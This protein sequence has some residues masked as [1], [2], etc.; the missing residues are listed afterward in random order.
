M[1]KNKN[2]IL[3][4][5]FDQKYILIILLI[6]SL[7]F[8]YFIQKNI[9]KIDK[10][11]QQ[12]NNTKVIF[13][14]YLYQVWYEKSYSSQ[15][16]IILGAVFDKIGVEAFLKPKN[17][18]V[19]NPKQTNKYIYFNVRTLNPIIVEDFIDKFEIEKKNFIEKEIEMIEN[20]R[21][22]KKDNNI[23][24]DREF[25]IF[26]IKNVKI[27][28]KGNKRVRE[29]SRDYAEKIISEHNGNDKNRSE[30][31]QSIKNEAIE[32]KKTFYYPEII[33]LLIYIGYFSLFFFVKLIRDNN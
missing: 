5:I 3:K 31:I 29:A 33:I 30:N 4:F 8:S 26:K 6:V 16:N 20:F 27:N 17:E 9:Q 21:T 10:L 15:V 19:P 28:I 18:Y 2:D 12:G 1:K 22:I 24:D 32:I 25:R 7:I 14:D 13:T 23:L 11:N